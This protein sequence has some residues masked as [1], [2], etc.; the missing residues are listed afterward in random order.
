M[1]T[2]LLIATHNPGKARE[3]QALLADLPLQITWLVAEG[4]TFEAPEQGATFA[5]N[6]RAK[7]RAYAQISGLLT[8]ADDSGL[9]VDALGGWPGVASARHAGPD[10]SDWDRLQI[11]LQR[12]S[13]L[14]YERRAAVFRCAVAVAT[15]T[16]D[17][18]LAEGSSA[19]VI[20][21]QPQGEGGFGYDPIFYVPKFGRTFAQLTPTEKHSISHRGRA[22]R[23]ARV[24]LQRYLHE[25]GPGR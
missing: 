20:A 17:L 22:A 24:L 21:E 23:R 16:A 3:Y 10:A 5:E 11:L 14:P 13:G 9:E 25:E 4:I 1:T 7:A 12:L 2:K 19:G 8:W 18:F 15:P 6:A